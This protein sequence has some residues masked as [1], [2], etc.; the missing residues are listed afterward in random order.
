MAEA[1]QAD[2]TTAI[3]QTPSHRLPRP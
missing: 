1:V 2:L 3:P